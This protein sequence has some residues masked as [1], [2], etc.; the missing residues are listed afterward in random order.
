MEGKSVVVRRVW[1]LVAFAVMIGPAV[2]RE[3]IP[4]GEAVAIVR[5]VRPDRQAAEVL[6]LF[7]GA[8][9]SD[10]AAALAAWKQR[11]DDT[12]LGKPLEAVIAL[13]N[14]EMTREWRSLDDSEIRIELDSATGEL[15]WLV[16]ISRD[17]GTLAAGITAMRL[18]YPGDRPLV[19]EGREL[20]VAQLSRS[21][22]PLAC[23]VGTAIVVASTRNLLERG[24]A[25][26]R[27]GRGMPPAGSQSTKLAQAAQEVQGVGS[28]LPGD[29][30]S[31]TVF[32]LEPGWMSSAPSASL[33]QRRMTEAFRAM[34][35]ARVDGAACLKDGSLALDIS[36]TMD[37]KKPRTGQSAHPVVEP[38]WLEA[39][40]STGIIAM[41]SVA[42]DA[43]PRSW[44]WAFAAVDRV[45]RVDPARAGL[46]PLRSRLNL[47]T[48]AAGVKLEAD[49]RPHLR[50]ISA[51]VMGDPSRPGRA[52]GGLLVL[53]LDEPATAQ[54]LV[55]Q[56]AP[57]LR[58][59]PGAGATSRTM[60]ARARERDIW[61]AW[62]DAALTNWAE[63]RPASGRSLATICGGWAGEGRKP[64]VR[65]GAIW[66]ARL[67]RP[68]GMT[69]ADPSSLRALADDPP[70]VWWG[71][72]EPGRERDSLRWGRLDERVKKFLETLPPAAGVAPSGPASRVSDSGFKIPN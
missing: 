10:P 47:L 32:R 43:D 68:A 45:E 59:L 20:P 15:G 57:R 2:G 39:L 65:V 24:V 58:N 54:R 33:L 63:G 38:A 13:F 48:M 29:R 26:A 16:L 27:S 37:G 11:T 17:D 3:T 25:L 31:G 49:L 22:P 69:H 28:V 21:G 46:A 67:W 51:C 36:M 23:Q 55:Q 66:P 53:H 72:S 19:V 12:G 35:C 5:L 71:W 30:D 60:T 50:G 1:V 8:R 14:P 42:I 9:W 7:E 44:D 40:P 64:P 70:V 62:G 18:T 61:L 41:I 6:R 56:S 4:D 34:G 52:T